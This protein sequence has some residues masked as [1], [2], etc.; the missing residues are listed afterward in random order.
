[1]RF[2]GLNGVIRCFDRCFELLELSKT[3]F[4]PKGEQCIS[5]IRAKTGYT[6]HV[7]M[8]K[9]EN[10]RGSTDE[11]GKG[12]H[13]EKKFTRRSFIQGAGVGTAMLAGAGLFGCAAPSSSAESSK[14]AATE[15]DTASWDKAPDAISPDQ[16]KE[17]VTAEVVIVG[18]GL[19]GCCAAMS[20]AQAG[21]KTVVLQKLD[22]VFNY[23]TGIASYDSKLQKEHGAPDKYDVDE[24]LSLYMSQATNI[25][26]RR[27]IELWKE[28]SGQDAD[29]LYDLMADTELDA[30]TWGWEEPEPIM[31]MFD[32][33]KAMP[34]LAEKAQELGV[35]FRFSTPAVQLE[36]DGERV[37][38]VFAQNE[39][40]E[41]LKFEAS[42]AVILCAGDYGNNPDMR[43]EFLP[44]AEGFQSAVTP[45]ANTGDGDLMAVWV[46]GAMDKKPHC[47]NIHYDLI[48]FST[49]QVFG[50]GIPWLRVNK[51]GER[52][53][54]EDVVYGLI[55]MQDAA[56]PESMHIDIFDANYEKYKPLMGTGL[57]RSDPPVEAFAPTWRTYLDDKGIDHSAMSDYEAIVKAHVEIGTMVE[58]DTIEDLAQKADIPVDTLVKTVAR[59]NELAELHKDK[60][61]G[62]PG[63]YLF[64]IAEGPFYA[65]PRKAFSLS[66]LSGLAINLDAQVLDEEGVAI[67][68]LYACGNNS[69]G[70]W[71]AGLVQPMSIPGVPS[72]RAIITAR[73]AVEA[74]AAEK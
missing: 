14:K 47:T 5:A 46:G 34:L 21:L 10:N 42:K 2:P 38:A 71:F 29:W 31:G 68:G 17:T 8:K 61:F 63:D 37:S 67:P 50:S 28:R 20:A 11:P 48:D 7:S 55:P 33:I 39:Q 56:Q 45:A 64:P 51:L 69:G 36:R 57:Y 19:A 43:A 66:C 32:C 24:L 26:D 35:E 4:T 18:A 44:H 23:A 52:F 40:G 58:A 22:R 27:F 70:G 15:N 9:E 53:S 60:D 74:I 65:V 25:P 6:C 30:P 3:R 12:T 59:Y 72:A 16:I 54:N 62:K 1:M 13:M 73:V 41:Y 49:A